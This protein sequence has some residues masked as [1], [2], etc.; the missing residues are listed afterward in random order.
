MDQE[1]GRNAGEQRA[2]RAQGEA[3]GRAS[4]RSKELGVAMD[5]APTANSE[6]AA[7]GGRAMETGR[8]SLGRDD[9]AGG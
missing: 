8:G 1:A 7:Q 2:S 6:E 4:G 5:R 9:R 3:R